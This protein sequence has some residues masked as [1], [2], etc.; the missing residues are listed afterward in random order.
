MSSSFGILFSIKVM[1][2]YYQGA[3]KD[4]DFHIPAD[5]AALLR[6]GRII[7]RTY[8]GV[9]YLLCER[10][11]DGTPIASLSGKTL[12]IGM[13]LK[14]HEFSNFT[15]VDYPVGVIPVY[16][17]ALDLVNLDTGSGVFLTAPLFSHDTSRPNRPVT[18][19]LKDSQNRTL[20]SKVITDPLDLS[21][22]PVDLRRHS[23]G[24]FSVTEKYNGITKKFN[25][26]LDPELLALNVSGIVEIRIEDSLY[27]G[28][29]R[30][31]G[32][33]FAAKE[34][35]LKYYVVGKKYSPAEMNSLL[36]NDG[37]FTEES[38]PRVQFTRV[39]QESFTSGDISPSLI[40]GNQSG[41]VLFKS[42]DPVA[43]QEKPRKKI[44]LTRNTDVIIKHLP[45]P[46]N[47]KS[48]ADMIIQISKP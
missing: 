25:Y 12:R 39:N 21:P 14:N 43:R 35:I 47:E 9:F 32:I 16:S 10:K 26:Y 11:E 4:F 1:H 8:Q 6:S 28:E 2:S 45:Q 37:G 44:Q 3:C 18:I 29:A 40:A 17:N 30:E 20:D 24:F 34:E 27:I 46:G 13:I 42:Q 15:R 41:V 36:V 31:F 23:Q 19:T 5:T 48:N 22:F 7:A 38:R 33:Q